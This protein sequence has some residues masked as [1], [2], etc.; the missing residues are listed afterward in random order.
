MGRM[1]LSDMAAVL[2][3]LLELSAVKMGEA[4]GLRSTPVTLLLMMRRAPEQAGTDNLLGVLLLRISK[5]T[6]NSVQK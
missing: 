5:S 2:L 1:R 6:V 4:E 3:Q